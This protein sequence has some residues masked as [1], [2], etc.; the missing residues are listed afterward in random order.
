MRAY[1]CWSRDV[2]MDTIYPEAVSPSRAVFLATH[3]PLRIR[4]ATIDGSTVS[5]I[6]EPIDEAV[7]LKDFLTRRPA[8]GT[9]LMPV[10]GDSGSGKSHLVRWVQE[11]LLLTPD[12]RR[13]VI[14]LPKMQTSLAAVVDALLSG[15]EG[16]QFDQLR[17][18]IHR[19]ST[20]M[21]Q[22]R[23]SRRLVAEL[24][25]S[26][27]ATMR[28]DVS[29]PAR[30][31]TGP[32]GLALLLQDPHVSDHMLQPGKFI[33]MIAKTLLADRG[34]GE[35]ERPPRFTA[36]DLP[37]DIRDETKAA[38][39]TQDL[40]GMFVANPDLQAA[41]VDMLNQYLEPAVLSAYSL[42]VGRLQKAMLDLR[43][44]YA[45]Q[46]KEI[47]LL[48]EDFA[49]IQ[50]VQRDLLEAVVE[51]AVRGGR[52]ELAPMRTLM[53]V[54]TGYFGA[55]PETVLTRIKASSE[56]AYDLDMLFS[57]ADT[58][59]SQITSFVGR[60]LNAVRI[61]R[62]ALERA[63]PQAGRTA[64][65]HCDTCPVM[66][67]CHEGFGTS[68]EGY[69]LYPFNAAAL[70]RAVHSTAPSD[71]PYAFVPRTVLTSV[72]HHVLVEHAD[73]IRLGCFPGA[74]FREHFPTAQQDEPLSLAV[75]KTI[76][77]SDVVDPERRMTILEFWGDAPERPDELNPTIAEAFSLP[78]L[79]FDDDGSRPPASDGPRQRPRTDPQRSEP[80]RVTTALQTKLT[81]VEDWAVRRR[82]LSQDAARDIRIIIAT[83]VAQRCQW[84]D[85]LMPAQSAGL[86]NKAW[87]N[88]SVVVSIEDAAAEGRVGTGQAP[89]R[90]KR[91]AEN[92]AFFQGILRAKEGSAAAEAEHVRR[93]NEIAGRHQ[94]DLVEAV[95]N[96]LGLNDESIVLGLRASL[97]GAALAG[98]AWPGMSEPELLSAALDVGSDW[99]RQDSAWRTSQWSAAW[100][101]HRPARRELVERICQG[102]GI[103][104]GATGQV[105]MIDAAQAM[106]LLRQAAARWTWDPPTGEL[107]TWVKPAATGLAAWDSLVNTQFDLLTARMAA[108][109]LLA[110]AGA[111]GRKTV[112]AIITA[113]D[114]SR[115]VGLG[116]GSEAQLVQ[117]LLDGA[118]NA[119]WKTLDELEQD[120][121]NASATGPSDTSSALRATAAIRDRGGSLAVVEGFLTAS[122]TWLVQTLPDAQRRT[123][124]AGD[125]AAA[126]VR[127][128]VEQWTAITKQE[129]A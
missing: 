80:G 101:R 38:R 121:L 1:L 127:Q 46:G 104:Q 15:I 26:L 68:A 35:P 81:A 92:A 120:L 89:I 82:V 20:S 5:P 61:G 90:F 2:A 83:A 85:P 71:R 96:H 9:L 19:L 115:A 60:Y 103:A 102:F 118:A 10:V 57:E 54:T 84:I 116:Q 112:D 111:R 59:E 105:R 107:P 114:Q 44:E 94:R 37:I 55:L 79:A 64:P 34:D 78:P 119:D 113:L 29:G 76:E 50:G 56:Y 51:V 99:V 95:R 73:A 36:D 66:A 124:T 91:T 123:S 42:G 129:P 106:P 16:A 125:A 6:G 100:D 39:V 72:L 40:L 126:A 3:A 128:L 21:D 88:S 70:V 17:A 31:L 24:Y 77:T 98:R 8:T 74:K 13:H 45:R 62:D 33:P 32:K 4:R 41:A 43:R 87:P 18:D 12:D 93:L 109:S 49:L 52:A 14:Y 25:G 86:V 97:L 69:G 28:K 65:N 63:E 108:V 110:P 67:Q 47:I 53:A 75:S 11:Q 58:G 22:D 7:V 122:D 117:G 27:A 48:I 30:D 23:L